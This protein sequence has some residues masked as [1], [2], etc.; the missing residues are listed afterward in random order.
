MK[1][2]Q[3]VNHWESLP[4]NQPIKPSAVPYKHEG[5]TYDQ[6]GIRITGSEIFI[7]GVLSRIKDLLQYEHGNTRLQVNYQETVD[8]YSG[9]K[10]GTYNCYVQVHQRGRCRL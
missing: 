10:T 9:Q 5:S 3:L 7:D 2:A 4:E 8:R 6:D 1:K